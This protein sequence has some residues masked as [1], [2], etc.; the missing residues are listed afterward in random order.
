MAL[1]PLYDIFDP[2]GEIRRRAELGLLEDEERDYL[3]VI[4]LGQRKPRLSDL[5][6]KEEQR[7]F[8]R[9]LAEMGSSGL[10]GAGW[11]LDTPG[12][13][14]RGTLSGGPMKGLSALWETS[15][16]RVTGREL[17]RQYNL[18][19]KDDT[20][21]N[22]VGSLA[23][24]TVL[25]PLSYANPLAILGRGALNPAGRALKAS[26]LLRNPA[27]DAYRGFEPSAVQ[28]M[29]GAAERAPGQGV[30]SYL[31]GQ[32][33]RSMLAEQPN[34]AE[35]VD[36]F[37]RNAQRFGVDPSD[38][39]API[40]SLM[41]V[42]IPGTNIGFDTDVFGR[43]FGDAVA[44]GLDT[45]GEW[46]KRAPGIGPL[47][48]GAAMLFHAPSGFTIDPDRQWNARIAAVDAE[49]ASAA[50]LRER[51][52]QM[53]AALQAAVPEE[54]VI[55]GVV[56]PIPEGLRSFQSADLQRALG[57]YVESPVGRRGGVFGP[58]LP[59]GA[60]TNYRTSGDAVA[61]WVLENVPEF[62][63]I[64][65]MM[66]NL[67]PRAATAAEDI[68]LAGPRWT[69]N[70]GTG[71]IPRQ[72][73][74]WE[75]PAPPVRPGVDPAEQR[76][77]ARGSRVLETQDNFGRSR[78]DYTDIE[79]GMRTFRA[80]TGNVD[81]RLD[82]RNLQVGLQTGNPRENR[83]AID[84]AFES[85]GLERP[86]RAEADEMMTTQ[87]YQ[88]ASPQE[89]IRMLRQ[90]VAGIRENKEN[91][92]EFLRSADQQFADTGTGVFDTPSWT[93]VLR[94]EGGQD[95]VRAN[96][97][98][99]VQELLRGAVN[100][101]ANQARGGGM[102]SLQ[103]AA[104][105]LRF[106][107]ENFRRM[108]AARN[109]GADVTNFSVPEQLVDSLRVLATP[110][111]ASE[112]ER[113]LLAGV[114]NFTNFFK[115]GALA[116]PAFHVRNTYSGAISA[117]A[118]GAFNPLD[119]W[120]G[121]QAS[122]GNY[123]PIARRLENAP[124][125]QGLNAQQR[126]DRFL[127]ETGAQRIG[128]GNL[129]DDVSGLPEQSIRGMYTGAN[130]GPS[131]GSRWYDSNRGWREFL[132]NFFSVRGVGIT[133]NPL[134]ENRN[135]FLA[136]NDA[137]G[138][139]AEDALRTGTFLNQ[140][141]KGVDPGEAADLTRMTQVD[142]S[143]AAFTPFE[144]QFM[145][146]LMPFYSFQKGILPSIGNQI[147][148]NPGGLQGQLVRAVTRGT[149]PT[150]DN[151]V[152]EYLRQ[153]AA[154]PLP[155]DLPWI[156]GG[157]P[158]EGLKRYL[159]NIDLPFESTFNM[160]T[161]G[162]GSSTSAALA[163]TIQK[164]G[165]NILGQTNPPLKAPI[166][167]ITNRQLYTGRQLSDLY[168]VLEQSLGP[169][170]RALENVVVNLPFGARAL[171]LYRQLNDDRLSPADARLKAAWN[172]LAGAK[173]T[174]VDE[175]RTKRLAA[176]QM[177]NQL[178]ETTPGVRTYENITVPDDVLA[179]MPEN[180]RKQYL[181]YRII[182]SEAAKRARERKKQE[183]ALDPLQVLGVTNRF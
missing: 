179:Q 29:L 148:Y 111:R 103:Q 62:Q 3:G 152:P 98:Q 15:D 54:A 1:S 33:V 164:T 68:G 36:A 155:E 9:S 135:P 67:G 131:L 91:L 79:G 177:L 52:Q 60:F 75:R 38:L 175:E 59:G 74:W 167:Y 17:L 50:R 43:A 49:A 109:N 150:E 173:L 31:R 114:D 30:R 92:A 157:T 27:V 170:G 77:W 69:S 94:Y 25:D 28:Q 129:L 163:D 162:V 55:D 70:Y 142:Y 174:D 140:I 56:T 22:F 137:V 122:R 139:A 72:T 80:L 10:A 102:L 58:T 76:P 100:V 160:F 6:P 154:I 53:R 51:T 176:R 41:D 48:R 20:W 146:R 81:P 24:E 180:Q 89:R 23:A 14:I 134:S 107:P 5:M 37:R 18:V 65:D 73:K 182:Q 119:W 44:G 105:A 130:T 40:A 169:S 113:G 39:D 153:S 120:A 127:A 21:L 132:D 128:S 104:E 95:R 84:A 96:A 133:R 166:E 108:W 11:L 138:Q 34:Y 13:V 12:A 151:F 183:A 116:S 126:I 106:D 19:G 78:Q 64:R 85:L 156:F 112:A 63:R 115:V 147:L 121:L 168:S 159:T 101:P 165:S 66:V 158:R 26:G 7:G 110:S 57:D 178:L 87:A 8:L 35:A 172:L 90:A 117:A 46:T 136:T 86:Y 171:G 45:F 123:A 141:R 181:L 161:P 16:D 71:F 124:G 61:D 47:T 118:Q 32:T 99:V 125:Y 149:Q 93:N 42:R 2:D 97:E 145:K 88:S 143:G 82:S 4:P 83:R 144:R